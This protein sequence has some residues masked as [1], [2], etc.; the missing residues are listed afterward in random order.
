MTILYYIIQYYI[1]MSLEDGITSNFEYKCDDHRDCKYI[2]LD[3]IDIDSVKLQYSIV[4]LKLE[5][6]EVD[7]ITGA[8]VHI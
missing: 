4:K 1:I 3:H 5:N 8:F 2:H 7:L 6:K